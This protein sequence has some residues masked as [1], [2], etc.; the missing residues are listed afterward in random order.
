MHAGDSGVECGWKVMLHS[1]AALSGE[2][3]DQRCSAGAARRRALVK[4]ASACMQVTVEENADVKSGFTVRLHFAENAW[5]SN[6]VLEKKVHYF[7]DGTAEVSAVPPQW[8]PGKVRHP[9]SLPDYLSIHCT[10]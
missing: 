8:L 6:S 2:P 4:M 9:H 10:I 7:E 1:A 3:L 5:F